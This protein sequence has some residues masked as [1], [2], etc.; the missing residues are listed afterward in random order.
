MT[1]RI[2]ASSV[3][4]IAEEELEKRICERSRIDP[5]NYDLAHIEQDVKNVKM[6]RFDKEA[7]KLSL[8]RQVY[9]LCLKY[10]TALA[11]C[12]YEEFVLKQPK[13]GV[14]HITKWTTHP[15]LKNRVF[16]TMNL[17]KKELERD[18]SKF[19][20]M[21]AAESD[22]IDRQDIARKYDMYGSSSEC[23]YDTKHG[24]KRRRGSGRSLNKKGRKTDDEIDNGNAYPVDS[25]KKL[26]GKVKKR[27]RELPMC[28]KPEFARL[29]SCNFADD[30]EHS[31]PAEKK[32][33]NKEWYEAK[34]RSGNRPDGSGKGGGSH[35]NG[36]K[37]LVK[38]SS[39]NTSLFFGS[40]CDGAV[41][42]RSMA[43]SGSEAPIMSHV[44]LADLQKS[45]STL[46]VRQLR[47]SITYANANRA[48]PP[49]ERANV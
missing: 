39:N 18:F 35:E 26:P 34:D 25:S 33:F 45:D 47:N 20:R 10:N 17:R 8:Q 27:K 22:A 46:V 14:Q 49:L 31:T 38:Q 37:S 3:E 48:G 24:T 32:R 36:I 21:L 23:E 30:Y 40:F 2:S 6:D 29:G 42:N 12:G 13:L 5:C 16:L 1:G 28:L 7:G 19:V 11:K 43:E 41:E 4:S 44:L 9:I 15:I